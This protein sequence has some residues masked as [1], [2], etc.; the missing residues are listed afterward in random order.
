MFDISYFF[1]EFY[2]YFPSKIKSK[3]GSSSQPIKLSF[4][5]VLINVVYRM[6]G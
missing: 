1:Q 2:N 4:S 6:K 5:K 3:K